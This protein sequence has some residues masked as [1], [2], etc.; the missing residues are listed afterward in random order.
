MLL[1]GLLQPLAPFG[2]AFLDSNLPPDEVFIP[3]LTGPV[4]TD[5]AEIDELFDI[6]RVQVRPELVRHKLDLDLP[7][8]WDTFDGVCSVACFIHL[9]ACAAKFSCDA[10]SISSADEQWGL[11]RS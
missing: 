6:L 8:E 4:D 2:K 9:G 11:D 10:S 3:S 7:E 5:G 1:Q